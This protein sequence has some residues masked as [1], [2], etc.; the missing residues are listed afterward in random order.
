V[1]SAR[2]AVSIVALMVLICSFAWNA[3]AVGTAGDFYLPFT[4]AWELMLGCLLA[5]FEHQSEKG[6]LTRALSPIVPTI[7]RYSAHI[8]RPELWSFTGVGL[9]LIAVGVLNQRSNFPGWWAVLPTSGA[10]LIVSANRSWFNRRVLSTPFMVFIGLISYPLYLWHWPLLSFANVVEPDPPV[11]MRVAA[12]L[13]A[14][15]LAW[16]TYRWIEQPIRRGQYRAIKIA[17]LCAIMMGLGGLGLV[18]AGEEGFTWRVPPIVR[19]VTNVVPNM[20]VDWR[21]H[22][23]LLEADDTRFAPECSG[24][25]HRPLLFL[26]GDSFAAA[27]YPGLKDLQRSIEF[28]IAQYNAA[29]CPPVLSFPVQGRPHCVED[30]QFAFS[31]LTQA[32][33]DL[34]LLDSA[35][36]WYGDLIPS[37]SEL[38]AKLHKLEVPRIIIVGS[39]PRREGGLPKALID[40]YRTHHQLIPERS[41]FRIHP[42]SVDNQQH[43]RQQVRRLA[44]YISVWDAL[45]NGTECVTRVGDTAADLIAFD[46]THLT[47][48]GST[49]VA[50]RIAPCLFPVLKMKLPMPRLDAEPSPVCSQIESSVSK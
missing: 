28:S 48:R 1:F 33:P 43:F 45:C 40:Y 47:L 38:I 26:W 16:V 29:G 3:K 14:F 50:Q 39:L 6:R 27:L 36:P 46:E 24:N 34:I 41:G 20:A 19:D 15:V 44:E 31:A 5:A 7:L 18:T 42:R 2:F 25:G 23:C 49:Y 12:I 8:R 11:H 13:A 21:L 9:I 32:K 30:N 35:W 4:R 22:K 37:L 17:G 10:C